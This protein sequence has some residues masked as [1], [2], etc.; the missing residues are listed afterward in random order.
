MPLWASLSDLASFMADTNF[1]QLLVTGSLEVLILRF[2]SFQIE[3]NSLVALLKAAKELEVYVV[4]AR[5]NKIMERLLEDQNIIQTIQATTEIGAD[6]LQE[7]A[8]SK[9]TKDFKL[10]YQREA[11]LEQSLQA[12][13]KVLSSDFLV[14]KVSAETVLASLNCLIWK[15]RKG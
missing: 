15:A 7:M 4:S 14:P 3:L 11:F 6:D 13:T 9:F 12:V 8:W 5:C 10:F 2:C 1:L